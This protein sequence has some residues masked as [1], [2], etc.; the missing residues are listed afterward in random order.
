M[1]VWRRDLERERE[2]GG[3]RRK[4]GKGRRGPRD[5]LRKKDDFF[6]L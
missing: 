6:L 1:G 4:F 2:R 3:L 5:R